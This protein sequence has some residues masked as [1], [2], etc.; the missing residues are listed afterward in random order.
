MGHRGSGLRVTGGRLVRRRLAVPDGKRVR[1]TSDRVRES[2]LSA[3]GERWDGRRVLD[4]F[5]GSG[6]LGVE[7][8]SR[9]AAHATFVERE[10]DVLAVLRRNLSNLGLAEQSRVVG[11]EARAA[12]RLFRREGRAFDAVWLDPPYD[13]RILLQEVLDGLS[14]HGLLAEGALVLVEHPA[15]AGP[16]GGERLRPIVEKSYGATGVTVYERRK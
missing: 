12:L 8:L 15:K 5:A 9:G 6:C 14:R 7:S 3:V 10:R 1:P 2:L 4:L 11:R 16:E 13:N